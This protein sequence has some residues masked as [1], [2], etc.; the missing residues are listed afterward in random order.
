MRFLRFI[1]AK[2]FL[3]STT[4]LWT[5]NEF[6]SVPKGTCSVVQYSATEIAIRSATDEQLLMPRVTIT[7]VEKESGNYSTINELLIAGSDFFISST[8]TTSLIPSTY[9]KQSSNGHSFDIQKGVLNKLRIRPE[10]LNEQQ[11]SSR[12][13]KGTVNSSTIVGQIFKASQDNINSVNLAMESAAGTTFDDFESYA[14]DA[15][16]QAAWIATEANHKAELETTIVHGGSQSMRLDV[17]GADIVGDE[18]EKTFTTTDFTN[19]TGQFWMY[20]N[21]EFKDVKMK[22]FV[23][24]ASANTSSASIVQSDKNVW[25]KIVID[26][27]SLVA[28]GGTAA[29]LTDI[30]GIGLRVE[31]EKRDGYVYIDDMI[32]VPPP[33]SVKVK[34]WDMGTTEPVTGVTSIDDGIQYDYLG[35]LGITG[36][37][38]SEVDV[39]LIGGF[40]IYHIENF[41]A[42]VALE[43][44]SNQLLTVG[45][46]YAITINYV[47][48]DTQIYGSKN[49]EAV[50]YEPSGYYTN[51][52][53]FTAPDE[54][55]AIT[56]VG[57]Y[58]D[59]MF[60]IFSTQN[61]YVINMGQV[62]DNVPGDDSKTDV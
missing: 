8:E 53:A 33:G 55:T 48:T 39:D 46:F 43:M 51:G 28:D 52:Y 40:R 50:R 5:V 3:N 26:V 19:F 12:E 24:D 7:D 1:M 58:A 35:D 62:A 25:T 18:W 54:A 45:N 11:E 31:K 16:L 60:T 49:T 47:D 30:V 59:L 36:V 9:S 27:N 56:K 23:E 21:K 32:S 22:V 15:A 41:V 17:E 61:V 6:L 10:I 42:G 13:V 4:S 20:C 37:Q 38:L 57:D 29:D 34:L 14:N 44:G 2:F